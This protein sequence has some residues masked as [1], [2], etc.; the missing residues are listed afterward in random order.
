[1]SAKSDIAVGSRLGISNMT[2]LSV[3]KQFAS[4]DML[5]SLNDTTGRVARTFIPSG[6]PIK[7]YM[8]FHG[9]GSLS[10]NLETHE[11]AITLQL[12]D[13]ELVDHSIMPEDMVDIMVTSNKNDKKFTRTI[14]QAVRVL[15]ASPKEQLTAHHGGNGGDK[16]TLALT[17]DLAEIVNEA[18][19]TGK[20]RLLLRSRVSTVVQNLA[21]AGPED[22]LPGSALMKDKVMENLTVSSQI[23]PPPP[24]PLPSAEM[25]AAQ[26]PGPIQWIVEVISGNHRETYAVPEK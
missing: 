9:H 8:L 26:S 18:A 14:C 20:I 13:D 6:E 7:D 21:G 17:P 23:I 16:I 24:P 22:L 5:I 4:P 15:M 3:P 11:R 25:P 19:E 10:S 12:D 1:M 2:F